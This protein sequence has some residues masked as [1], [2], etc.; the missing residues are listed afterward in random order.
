MLGHAE[1]LAYAPWPTFD[2]SLTT[3]DKIEVPVQ[4]NGKVRRR[5]TAPAGVDEATL[6]QMA[7]EAVKDLTGR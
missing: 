3:E 1:S 4:I 7:L 6:K 2:P 5:I